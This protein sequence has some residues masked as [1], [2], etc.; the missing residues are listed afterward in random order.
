MYNRKRINLQK[1]YTC[2]EVVAC[3]LYATKM[4]LIHKEMSQIVLDIR[5]FNPCV[6]LLVLCVSLIQRNHA[7][8]SLWAGKCVESS[9]THRIHWR[10]GNVALGGTSLSE[11]WVPGL[12]C[13]QPKRYLL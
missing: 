8:S 6:C 9:L 12:Q 5:H 3:S 11:S 1:T 4:Q 7:F 13:F 10:H 2:E